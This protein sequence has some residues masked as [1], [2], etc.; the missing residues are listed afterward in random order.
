MRILRSIVA[1]GMFALLVAC[2][3]S[4][5][6]VYADAAQSY[7]IAV[8]A[9]SYLVASGCV[10]RQEGAKWLPAVDAGES[11]LGEMKVAVAIDDADKL[12]VARACLDGALNELQLFFAEV[13]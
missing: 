1:L 3:T 11:C 6:Q 12:A 2:Q 10:S 5:R 9:G 4:S 8:E 13:Q 7:T